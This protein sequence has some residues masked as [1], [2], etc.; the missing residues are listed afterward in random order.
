MEEG[1]KMGLETCGSD[2]AGGSPLGFSSPVP[3]NEKSVFLGPVLVEVEKTLLVEQGLSTE[4]R[5]INNGI[6]G[7]VVTKWKRKAREEHEALGESVA[8]GQKAR[9]K[10][11]NK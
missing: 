6:C 4:R 2:V 11:G 10:T 3:R 5:E 7:G 1:K 8:P 9:K